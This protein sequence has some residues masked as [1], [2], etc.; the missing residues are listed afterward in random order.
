[1]TRIYK[2]AVIGGGP[3]GLAA[4]TEAASRGGNVLIIE[5]E[6]RLGGILKQCVHDGFGV[7]RFGEKLSGCEYAQRFIDRAREMENIDIKTLTYVIDIKAR[8]ENGNFRIIT[9]SDC[10][11]ET[12]AAQN[13]VLAN[14]CRER[15]PKQVNIHGTRPAGVMTAGTAQNFVNLQGF[16]PTKRCVILGSGDIGLIMARRLTLEGAEV[17]GVYEA[18]SS[19]SGLARNISQ[20]L[21]DFGIPLHLSKT[22]KRVLGNSRVEAVEICSVDQNMRYIEGTEEVIPCDALIVSVGLIPENELA[23][24]LRIEIDPLTKGPFVDQNMNTLTNGVYSVGNA[25]HV[26]DLVDYVSETAQT[27]GR[28]LSDGGTA[29]ELL[30]IAQSGFL[31]FVPQ[32]LDVNCL[33]D[34][35]TFYFRT[36]RVLE[37]AKL[38]LKID[39][40]TVFEKKYANLKPPE[41]EK[42]TVPLKARSGQKIEFALEE[43]KERL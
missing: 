35:T 28:A 13:L 25:L 16:L 20:C 34:K 31:Y 14:G 17:A 11:I 42:L 2:A 4:A 5:R 23:E 41:M 43:A 40:E 19:P 18:K 37:K 15:T 3:A 36:A 9:T 26:H 22:M 38:T 12:F 33:N 39:G 29:R 10:G 7:I 32:Y 8:D 27:A 6:A 1:M 30:K 24:K 21:D